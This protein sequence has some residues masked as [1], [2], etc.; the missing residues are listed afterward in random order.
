MVHGFGRG[1]LGKNLV[2][3]VK[4]MFEEERVALPDIVRHTRG[5]A[6]RRVLS[7]D[8]TPK[9]NSQ[10]RVVTTER[11]EENELTIDVDTN[12][13]VRSAGQHIWTVG[14]KGHA[15]P[16]LVEI[17]L[18]VAIAE[19]RLHDLSRRAVVAD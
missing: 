8:K 10:G 7:K 4:D 17:A 3:L 12:P 15:H 11:V 9:R 14:H 18:R 6:L 5:E 13:P 19:G 1:S 2:R 16:A